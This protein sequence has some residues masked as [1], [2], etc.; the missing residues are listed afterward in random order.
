MYIRK[1][2]KIKIQCM[3][4]SWKD[5]ENVFRKD[6]KLLLK[7]VP[8]L[9]KLGTVS[10]DSATQENKSMLYTLSCCMI[11]IK[12]RYSIH[13]IISEVPLESIF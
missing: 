9:L 11:M 1:E 10:D 4:F 7:C 5:K 13:K 6:P 12:V 8:T 2:N 3:N